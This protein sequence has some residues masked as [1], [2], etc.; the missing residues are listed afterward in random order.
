MA[1]HG[2]SITG[3]YLGLRLEE[4]KKWWSCLKKRYSFSRIS[5]AIPCTKCSHKYSS[6]VVDPEPEMAFK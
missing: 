3:S 6:N 1:Y 4:K 5:L 2:L